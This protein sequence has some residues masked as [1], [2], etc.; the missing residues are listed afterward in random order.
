M[1]L[2]TTA[3]PSDGSAH[4]RFQPLHKGHLEYLLASLERCDHLYVGIT[5]YLH[6][7][8]V[9]VDSADAAHRSLPEN[10]PLSYFERM[11]I[12]EIALEAEGVEHERF[13]I[14][15]FPIEEPLLLT[16]FLP[17]SVP[18]FTTTYDE[19]NQEK[20]Q[21]L[22]R[23]GYEVINLWDRDHKDYEGKAVRTLMRTGDEAWKTQVPD[24][25]VQYLEETRIPERLPSL[26][27]PQ[28]G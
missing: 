25:V 13:D 8:L 23:A 15:P 2:T 9:Q 3:R 5:Q 20:I 19:W 7:R 12:I 26:I 17:T 28:K 22:E 21:T 10:N 6:D 4:G 27:L 1:T 11:R 24:A 14:L 16:Q 18:V